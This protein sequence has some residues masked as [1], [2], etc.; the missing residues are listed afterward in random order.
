[1]ITNEQRKGGGGR[2]GKGRKRE[3]TREKARRERLR[4][5]SIGEDDVLVRKASS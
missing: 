4:V 3:G 5:L 1:M 2:G